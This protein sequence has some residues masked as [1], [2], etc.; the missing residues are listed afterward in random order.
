M[1]RDVRAAVMTAKKASAHDDPK[2]AANLARYLKGNHPLVPH[3]VY[4]GTTGDFHAFNPRHGNNGQYDPTD[5]DIIKHEGGLVER[6]LR[7]VRA[8]GGLVGPVL[9]SG[10]AQAASALPQPSGPTPQMLATLANRPGVKPDELANAGVPTQ[11][12]VTRDELAQHF[13]NALPAVKALTLREQDDPYMQS[14]DGM[15]AKFGPNENPSLSI[16]G[17]T[18]Y[19]EKLLTVPAV[20]PWEVYDA[21][22]ERTHSRH[23]TERDARDAAHEGNQYEDADLHYARDPRAPEPFMGSH[24]EDVPSVVAHMRLQDRTLP[25]GEKALHLEEL[26]SDWGQ[27]ARKHGFKDP[28][29]EKF[30]NTQLTKLRDAFGAQLGPATAALDRTRE[31]NR[32]LHGSEVPRDKEDAMYAAYHK[33][34][35]PLEDAYNRAAQPHI[36]ALRKLS[37]GV[38]RGPYVDNTQKWTDLGLKHALHEAASGGYDRLMW[39]P[40]EDQAARYDLSKHLGSLKAVPHTTATGDQVVHLTGYH[41]EHGTPVLSTTVPAD[42]LD[43]YVGKDIAT[44]IHEGMAPAPEGWEVYNTKSGHV[45]PTHATERYARNQIATAYPESLRPNLDVR[46]TASTGQKRPVTLRGLDLK[47]GGEG[48]KGYYDNIVPKRL[49]A[50]AKQHDPSATLEP[51]VAQL[52]KDLDT[53]SREAYDMAV[54]AHDPDDWARM[55]ESDQRDAVAAMRPY[56]HPTTPK[57]FPSLRITPAMRESILRKGFPAYARGGEVD[58]PAHQEATRGKEYV[59]PEAPLKHY[60]HS[61]EADS[62]API[63]TI[64]PTVDRAL[65]LTAQGRR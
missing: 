5:P 50:L 7:M 32:R 22:T 11:P 14:E 3:V 19:R 26:Q 42:E 2:R 31:E 53:H 34:R 47:V 15:D 63:H 16:P 6:A 62:V 33:I 52:P 28:E 43:K 9:Y 48:M 54:D 4:H 24:W 60:A 30:H 38:P 21:N 35:A 17:G 13:E 64:A 51:T 41:P 10:A 1:S 58:P 36:D 44:K 37:D 46:P 39:T 45:G 23:W 27:A 18:N 56:V 59:A 55:R 40:G 61:L 20:K 12:T 29:A 49:L 65:R 8:A 57:Q 25:T